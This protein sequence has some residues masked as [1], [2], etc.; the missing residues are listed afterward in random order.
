MRNIIIFSMLSLV[1]TSCFKERIEL[2]NNT[3]ENKKLVINAWITSLD[4]PQFVSLSQTVNYLGGFQPE[5][6]SDAVVQLNDGMTTYDLVEKEPGFYYL[7]D[8]WMAR[9]GEEYELT[10]NYEDKEYTARHQMRVCPEIE[11]PDFDLYDE[12]DSLEQYATFFNLQEPEGKGDAYYGIDYLKGTTDGDSLFNGGYV[13]DDFLDGEY[14]EGI[15]LSE[16]DRLYEMGDTVILELYSIGAETADYLQDI[17]N[18]VFRGGLFDPPPANVRTN[19]DGGAVGYFIMSDA[20]R[21]TVI[22]Q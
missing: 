1:L 11:F 7:P 14:L 2:D 8:D 3:N 15:L 19:I 17:E 20:K 22:I 10:V 21:A 16:E 5:L 18:E 6:V 4:E 12:T 13:N 9:V